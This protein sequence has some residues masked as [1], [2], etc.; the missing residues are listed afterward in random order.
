MGFSFRKS[1]KI[2]AVRVNLS[3]RGLGASAG[4][5]GARI[6]VNSAGRRYSS[7]SIPG[8]GLR[9]TSGGGGGRRR[10]AIDDDGVEY[11]ELED[12]SFQP[13]EETQVAER[14][15]GFFRSI[16]RGLGLVAILI[17]FAFVAAAVNVYLSADKLSKPVLV[18]TLTSLF[19]F[20]V[21]GK[22]RS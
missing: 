16:W 19:C 18:L 20:V 9:Y 10:T 14:R 6:G 15:P 17:G 3:N 2:G 5:K 1:F 8:T 7:F 4:V 12:G 13:V 22:M 21:G 11:F